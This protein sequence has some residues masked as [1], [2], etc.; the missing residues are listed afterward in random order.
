MNLKLTFA[1]LISIAATGVSQAGDTQ[2]AAAIVTECQ[3]TNNSVCAVV[4]A[5][6]A[7]VAIA[8]QGRVTVRRI[9]DQRVVWRSYHCS[10]SAL[11]FSADGNTL[12]SAGRDRAGLTTIRLWNA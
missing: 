2:P 9:S 7:F 12:G 6:T 8:G 10:V 4:S 3:E 11:A 1:C 5:D